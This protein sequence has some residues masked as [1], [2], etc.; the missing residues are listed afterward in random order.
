MTVAEVMST[1]GNANGNLENSS[2]I[3]SM[4]RSFV[5]EGRG[6]LKSIF[7]LSKSKVALINVPGTAV[8]NLGLSSAQTGQ[9]VLVLFN[10]LDGKG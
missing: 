7:S 4:S 9:E 10:I 1:H 5:S 2:T 8:W 6:P 3:V